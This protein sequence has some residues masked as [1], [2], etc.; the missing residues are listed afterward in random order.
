MKKK[1]LSLTDIEKSRILEMHY[2]ASGKNFISENKYDYYKDSTQMNSNGILIE[3]FSIDEQTKLRQAMSR[4][5][6]AIQGT[7]LMVK[8]QNWRQKKFIKKNGLPTKEQLIAKESDVVKNTPG[9]D[10]VIYLM[11]NKRTMD[12]FTISYWNG[13]PALG[14]DGSPEDKQKMGQ[15]ITQLSRFN[16]VDV[17]TGYE[18]Q[19]PTKIEL[20]QFIEVFSKSFKSQ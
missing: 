19:E 7:P 20:T 12:K 18:N 6:T 8:W 5:R 4:A 15:L 14:G 9:Y 3:S 16:G 13:L 2:K 1:L 11:F 10:T 17:P